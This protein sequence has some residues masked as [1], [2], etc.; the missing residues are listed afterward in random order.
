MVTIRFNADSSRKTK[1]IHA[2]SRAPQPLSPGLTPKAGLVSEDCDGTFWFMARNI[3][4]QIG[5]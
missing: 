5:T 2:F 1:P 3:P 4:I